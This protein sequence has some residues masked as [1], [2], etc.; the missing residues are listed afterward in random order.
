MPSASTDPDTA[1]SDRWVT[2]QWVGVGVAI[3]AIIVVAIMFFGTN[4]GGGGGG[5]H[6]LGPDSP[7]ANTATPR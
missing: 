5:G 6:G 3:I 1:P 2:L 4:T 7:P